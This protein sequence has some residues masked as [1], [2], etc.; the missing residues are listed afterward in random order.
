ML[1]KDQIDAGVT[2]LSANKLTPE[3][4]D[5]LVGVMRMFFEGLEDKYGYD[6][7]SKLLALD[8]GGDTA[9]TAAQVAACINEMEALG[10]GVSS[11]QGGSDALYYKE[12][13][14]Y[15]QYVVLVH[16]KFYPL[17]AEFTQYP[18]S[19][20]SLAG[21]NTGTVMSERV[22]PRFMGISERG[23]RRPFST[24]WRRGGW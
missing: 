17:P 4:V 15:W 7:R 16:T 13:D 5:K 12:K 18:L 22:E 23:L 6:W 11:L 3:D 2:R 9:R 21:G 10:F 24:R 20:R 8:D 14:E 19:R 1:T